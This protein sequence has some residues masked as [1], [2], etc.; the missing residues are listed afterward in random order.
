MPNQIQ[1]GEAAH[2]VG[3]VLCAVANGSLGSFEGTKNR[4]FT[5]CKRRH[6]YRRLP[7]G[8][9]PRQLQP[10]YPL[11]CRVRGGRRDNH[12][13]ALFR[14]GRRYAYIAAVAFPDYRRISRRRLF[15][16][17]GIVCGRAGMAC[18]CRKGDSQLVLARGGEGICAAVALATRGFVEI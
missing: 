8:C 1:I 3:A 2:R 18:S 10:Q 14:H 15:H 16:G 4:N 11:L 12:S 7:R 5:L 6:R 9:R 17:E 13:V